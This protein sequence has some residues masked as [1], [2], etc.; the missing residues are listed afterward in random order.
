MLIHNRSDQV[1]CV[2]DTLEGPPGNKAMIMQ[3]GASLNIEDTLPYLRITFATT[4]DGLRVAIK[5]ELI[6]LPASGIHL[7]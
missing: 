1:I 6:V 3:P 5:E 2:G 4:A 7:N